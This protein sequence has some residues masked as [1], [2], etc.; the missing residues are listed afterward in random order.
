MSYFREARAAKTAA[1]VVTHYRSMTDYDLHKCLYVST[2]TIEDIH[3]APGAP[4]GP[5]EQGKKGDRGTNKY[6]IRW[7]K[8]FSNNMFREPL[9]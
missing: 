5:G 3:V 8:E 7:N 2:V 4:G 6:I 1:R 9:F